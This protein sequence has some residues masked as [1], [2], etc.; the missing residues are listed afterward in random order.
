MPAHSSE[1]EISD[2]EGDAS[3]VWNNHRYGVVVQDLATQWTQSNPCKNKNSQV[4]EKS[5]K[6]SRAITK[7]KSYL[8]GQFI[9]IWQIL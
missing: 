9:R 5:T 2:S 7:A 8:Y 4:T 3:K 1:R 6:V